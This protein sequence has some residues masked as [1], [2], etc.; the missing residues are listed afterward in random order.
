MK[1][2]TG[3]LVIDDDAIVQ[4]SLVS[5]LTPDYAVHLASSGE[6]GLAEYERLVPDLVLLDVMLPQ[7]SGLAVLRRLK[8]M[9]ADLPVLMMSA[10]T[11]VQTAVQA[12]KLG[13]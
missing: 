7:M 5:T 8:R 4:R 9:S 6:E 13:A 1:G 10:Y 11:E 12:I 3:V 2:S